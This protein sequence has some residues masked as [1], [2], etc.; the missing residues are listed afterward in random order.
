MLTG[1]SYSC[2]YD[3]CCNMY[4]RYVL[5][6]APAAAV[7]SYCSSS[8]EDVVVYVVTFECRYI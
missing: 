4:P 7:L 1:T 5:F 8:I 2:Y 6:T 3:Y